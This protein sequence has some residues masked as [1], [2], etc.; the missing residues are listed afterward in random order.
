MAEPN[1]PETVDTP[2]G[3]QL[4]PVP[5]ARCGAFDV[6]DGTTVVFDRGAETPGSAPTALW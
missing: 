6:G 3:E 4:P 2:E 5:D 1:E